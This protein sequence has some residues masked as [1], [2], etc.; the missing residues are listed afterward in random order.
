MKVR[1]KLLEEAL[2]SSPS[3]E[4]LMGTYIASKAPTADLTSEEIDNIKAQ[5]A[6]DR[7][8]V[9]PKQADSRRWKMT[10]WRIGTAGWR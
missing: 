8:T 7:I 2:G 5:N 4:D 10:R 9:F 3:N 1:I 6:E